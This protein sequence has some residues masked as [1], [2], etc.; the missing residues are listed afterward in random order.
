MLNAARAYIRKLGE[1]LILAERSIFWKKK[2]TKSALHLNKE[3]NNFHKRGQR[4]IAGLM[5]GL[6]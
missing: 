3:F 5:K 1:H 2:G 6:D 4:P